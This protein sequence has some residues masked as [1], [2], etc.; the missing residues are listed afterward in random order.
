MSDTIKE[1]AIIL[2]WAAI[3]LAVYGPAIL[4]IIK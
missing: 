3:T 1:W 4:A 2:L